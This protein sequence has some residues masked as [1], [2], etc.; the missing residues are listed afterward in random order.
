[1]Y[2]AA[3]LNDSDGT[4]LTITDTTDTTD[5]TVNIQLTN[6]GSDVNTDY[7]GIDEIDVST[8]ET[9]NITANTNALGTASAN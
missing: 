2:V 6:I 1:V 9:I 7:F 3:Y 4:K 5:D 8:Y